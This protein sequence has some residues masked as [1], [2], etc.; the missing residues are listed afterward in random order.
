[1]LKKDEVIDRL[2]EARAYTSYPL[3]LNQMGWKHDVITTT[4]L[5]NSPGFQRHNLPLHVNQIPQTRRN[6]LPD[7]IKDIHGFHHLV[8][9]D[10]ILLVPFKNVDG[11]PRYIAGQSGDGIMAFNPMENP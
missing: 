8:L 7:W 1:M 5:E 11:R 10:K 4:I 2:A 3:P 6:I 9:P